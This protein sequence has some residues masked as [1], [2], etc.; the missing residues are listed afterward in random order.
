ML[1]AA[2]VIICLA[3]CAGAA[4]AEVL[5]PKT[6][7]KKA[8]VFGVDPTLIGGTPAPA[9]DWPASVY[10]HMGNAACSATVVG[11]RALLI[12]SHCVSDG[13]SASFSVGANQ[14]R[15]TC[16]HAPGYDGARGNSTYDWTLCLVDRKVDG[17]VY[18]S[19][20]TDLAEV[21]LAMQLRLTGYG[22]IRAGG[23]GGNDGTF[24]IGKSAVTV[25]PTKTGNSADIV[26]VGAAA[27]CYGD[28][29]GAAYVERD[30]GS[31]AVVGVNSRGDIART[32][33]LPSLAH[34]VFVTFANA[35]QTRTGQKICGVSDVAVGCR[36]GMPEDPDDDDDPAPSCAAQFRDYESALSMSAGKFQSL[37]ACIEA[38]H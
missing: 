10:A 31:R 37:K 36:N 29:G 8:D 30:D 6:T 22:C 28:S 12:A 3:L 17:I 21:K 11:E 20:S 34:Q 9:A 35:W 23:G 13:G 38:A 25:V 16:S 27:L 18:E 26:T 1:K 7:E 2:H 32:S 19:V 15:A 5:D 24:R 14:Y 33:Y 4:H